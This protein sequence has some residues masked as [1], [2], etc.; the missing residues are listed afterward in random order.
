[1]TRLTIERLF[2]SPSLNGSVPTQVR[3]SPDGKFVTYL[4]NPPEDRERL[5][6][7]AYELASGTSDRLIDASRVHATGELSA[8]EKAERERR[9]QFSAGLSSYRWLP[10]GRRICGML[11]GAVYLFDHENASLRAITDEGLRQTD[12]TVSPGGR[13]LSYIRAGDL[14]LYDL[15]LAREER[16]TND[17]SDCVTNGLAEFV[18][19][20]EMHRF[21]GHWWAPDDAH[22]VFARVDNSSIPETHRYEFTASELVAVA[23]RYPYAGA[24]NAKVDLY[25]IDLRTRALHPIEYRQ[26]P[27][28]YLARVNV[29]AD[30]AVVQVQSRDQ[31]TLTVT[32]FPFD[33]GAP[34]ELLTERQPAWINLHNNF[35]FVGA[36]TD[37]LWTS[38]RSGTSQLYLHRADGTSVQLTRGAGRI[39]EVVH[40]DASH[41]FVLGWTVRPT[42]QHLLK[43]ALDGTGEPEVL[44]RVPGW[45]EAVIDPTGAWFVDRY[46]NV[47]QPTCLE[48]RSLAAETPARQLTANALV[49]G[50]PYFPHVADHAEPSFGSFAAADGQTL[51]YRLTL[52]RGYDAKAR[53]PVLVHVYGGPGVQRVRDEWAPLTNQLF[54]NLGVAVF[55]LDNR[56]GGNR[57]KSFEDPI[58]GRLGYIEVDD[59]L[60]GIDFIEQQAWAD[61]QRIG[62]IGHSYGGFMTLMLMA[63]NDGRIRCGVSTAPV[64]DWRL[65]DT[66]YTERYLSTPQMN[67]NG[68]RES[69]VLSHVDAIGGALLLMHGMADDNVLFANSSALMKALQNRGFP[70]ELMLYPG[71]KHAMQERDVSIHRYRTILDFLQRKLIS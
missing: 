25:V 38:E 52:P 21:E 40:S 3:F 16:L 8:A 12:L 58:C 18:A 49:E 9:R 7:Y 50:H 53:V 26:R 6:L 1:V 43:V 39:N 47:A 71:A 55:E 14:Y 54:A 37:F 56:G 10:D 67:A 11:D 66:H 65:Y 22:V 32:A 15:V 62:V 60:A 70:F 68:Y 29:A 28:D 46:S 33:G 48:L 19:Q 2:S 42:E 17:A 4:A 20:E 34:R 30:C 36:G 44:T 59:Q 61:P 64:T 23:Q 27:D 35:R 63:R 69:C 13:Y 45:H 57:A 24:S 51:W 31:R 41:A 5:D